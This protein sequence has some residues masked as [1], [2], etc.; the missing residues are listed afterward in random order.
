ML[1]QDHCTK[2]VNIIRC[3]IEQYPS[4]KPFGGLR[5]IPARQCTSANILMAFNCHIYTDGI[6]KRADKFQKCCRST[7]AS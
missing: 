3:N 7:R 1:E 2:N 4:A 5:F 6:S